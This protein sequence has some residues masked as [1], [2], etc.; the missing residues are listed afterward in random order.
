MN[1]NI[2]LSPLKASEFFEKLEFEYLEEDEVDV[3][4]EE[5]EQEIMTDFADM[6]SPT[7][8]MFYNE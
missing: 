2:P 5:L 3:P 8:M 6:G 1:P 4:N 7:P